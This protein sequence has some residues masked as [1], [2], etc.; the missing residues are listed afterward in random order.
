VSVDQDVHQPGRSGAHVGAEIGVARLRLADAAAELGTLLGALGE[1]REAEP[2][3]RQAVDIFE[4]CGG[5]HQARLAGAL[6]ALGTACAARG[7]L[8]EAERLC[9]RALQVIDTRAL[10]RS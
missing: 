4:S 2:L 7:R 8:D 9:R 3:L 5:P 1:H 10:E 6:S